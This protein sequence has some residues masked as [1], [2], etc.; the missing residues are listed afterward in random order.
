M[1][2][3]RKIFEHFL[4]FG[5]FSLSGRD[6]AM[7]VNNLLLFFE[8]FQDYFIVFSFLMI[9]DTEHVHLDGTQIATMDHLR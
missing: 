5:A 6:C 4:G 1:L 9:L 8:L 2:K 3:A 7:I